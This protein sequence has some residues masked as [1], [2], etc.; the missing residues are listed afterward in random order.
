MKSSSPSSTD[1][2][3]Q[4][5]AVELKHYHSEFTAQ[6]CLV[7]GVTFLSMLIVLWRVLVRGQWEML[8]MAAM[9]IGIG[10]CIEPFLK[11]HER[12]H[13]KV[14]RLFG[15]RFE[16]GELSLAHQDIASIVWPKKAVDQ[17]VS[18]TLQVRVDNET[19]GFGS[20]E[21]PA[22]TQGLVD[23]E[24]ALNHFQAGDRLLVIHYLQ[25]IETEHED[26]D[27]FSGRYLENW[28]EQPSQL[29]PVWFA[30]AIKRHPF[31]ASFFW[32]PYMSVIYLAQVPL[33]I[34]WAIGFS[35]AISGVINLRMMHG[36]WLSPIGESIVGFAAALILAGVIAACFPNTRSR[37]SVSE[38]ERTAGYLA[39]VILALALIFSPLA[40][41]LLLMVGFK[42]L[43]MLTLQI[44]IWL[45]CVPFFVQR[46]RKAK[47]KKDNFEAHVERANQ[48]W[49]AHLESF[50]QDAGSETHSFV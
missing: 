48:L 17:K 33:T 44:S 25:Q 43:A 46:G 30:E 6:V 18:V 11:W 12:K 23:W 9:M 2:N 35:V 32:G 4:A 21:E 36:T 24:I 22:E 39:L 41:Q 47:E 13:S 16:L 45:P 7:G 15:D 10:A 40:V 50:Y 38:S 3:T 34:Y 42:I 28:L 27:A 37:R 49:Q 31:W 19:D 26:W 8:L 20:G 5:P 1:E 29:I 14:Y